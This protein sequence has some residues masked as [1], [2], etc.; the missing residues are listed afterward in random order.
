MRVHQV[1]F[2]TWQ[3][4]NG[5]VRNDQ[6]CFWGRFRSRCH[7]VIFQ[8]FKRFKDSRQ[9][10]E[11]DSR[12]G[13]PPKSQNDDVVVT[14]CDN[15]RNYSRLTVRELKNETGISIGF[16]R[17]MLTENLQ[18]RRVARKFVPRLL[19]M[20][21]KEKRL[22]TC[23]KLKN[24]P[25]DDEFHTKHYRGWWVHGIMDTIRKQ[26]SGYFNEKQNFLFSQKK[27]ANVKCQ[28]NGN[29]FFL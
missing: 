15:V 22:T 8:W 9:L 5:N 17:E 11:D 4:C 12:S 6:N 20:G 25:A 3:K 19:T 7:S 24:R 23:Q 14:I 10:T 26:S 16:G 18:T 1:L 13:R 28:N 21:Q 29:W 2:Q 27:F